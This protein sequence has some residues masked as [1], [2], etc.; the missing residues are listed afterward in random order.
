MFKNYL[1]SIWR[2][3]SR[4]KAF[5]IINVLGLAIGM[6]A[7]MLIAQF[8]LHELSY[9]RFWKNSEQIYRVQQDRYNKG[10]LTTRWASGCLG[11]GPDLKANFPEVNAFVRMT[12]SNAVLA[13]GDTFFK[14]EGVYYTSSDFFKVFSMPLVEGVDSSALKGPYRMVISRSLAKKYFGN[15]SPIGK[16][17]KNNG[18]T[19]Y[20]ITGMYEDLP[21]NS[22]MQID[23]L[24]SFS[25]YA[26]L[27]KRDEAALNMYQWDGFLTYIRLNENA[28]AEALEAKLPALVEKKAGEEM[29][30]DNAGMV[31]HL[32]Q[33]SDIHLDSDFIGEF[34]ANGDRNTTYF[35][36]IVA[37]LI[38][39]IAWINYVNLS[40]AKSIERAREV[41]VR[42][43]MGGFR[44]QLVQQFL[45]ESLLL[46][47]LAVSIAAGSVLILTPWF[48]EL[49]GRELGYQLFKEQLFWMWLSVLIVAGA[50]LSG[51]YPAFVLSAYRPVEVL[52]GRFKNTNQG[53][54]FR[55]GMVVTQFMASI[56]LIVGTFTVYNQITH[57][58]SQKLGIN[59]DQTLILRAPNIVDSTYNQKF[60][61]FKQKLNDYAEV[62]SVTASSSIPG[63]QPGWNAGGI[64]RLSQRED[65]ANQYRVVEM[66]HDFVKSYGLEMVAGRPFANGSPKEEKTV[67][68]NESA[69]RLMGFEK[70]EDAI[71]D[72]INFWGDTFR[73][74]GVVKNFR[75]ESSKK[76]FD[77]LIFRYSSAPGGYYSI[78]FNAKNVN[79]SLSRFE[80]DWK[81]F[82]P[83]NPFNFFFLDDHYNKQYKA[84]QQFGEV[85]GLFSALAIFIACLGL[86]GLSSLTAIQ[87]TKEIGVRKVL[88]ASVPGIISLMSKDY[89]VLMGVAMIL[90]VPL[91]WWAMNS[92]LQSFANR[93][94]L[95]W[96]IFAI[97]SFVV[98]AIALLTVSI[99]TLKAARTNPVKSLRYE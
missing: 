74:V 27:L 66:D 95:S 28:S 62:V 36:L 83:G 17:L 50:L 92:W 93:I 59:I 84:D 89:L 73:I 77:P 44:T 16:H 52:K 60:E 67:M 53:V 2:Y 3:I 54:F 55:K 22:H 39:I 14:E 47:T 5:T 61:V 80:G 32:Q 48:S 26:I 30:R 46:N 86:F 25:T 85:F 38:V 9:D 7:C 81:E 42:K 23:A 75:Q 4:N 99:H 57:M 88:G 24:L 98:I 87:R 97:P 37:I 71:E 21:P 19:D 43:V 51:I 10:E 65:E 82:F 11:I 6:A 20:E 31:F 56:T 33:I 15:E 90:A 68:M 1:T 63:E 70:V 18:S 40:T 58:R 78:K 45:F 79:E 34:K 29:K 94:P 13:N 69:A 76:A 8:V 64:R 96:W 91:S 72:H 49:T 41:G 12:K 35:L